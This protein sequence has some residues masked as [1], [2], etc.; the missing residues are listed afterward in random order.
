MLQEGILPQHTHTH[1]QCDSIITGLKLFLH[2]RTYPL[3]SAVQFKV[4]CLDC[5]KSPLIVPLLK[6]FMKHTVWNSSVSCYFSWMVVT[7]WVSGSPISRHLI[8]CEDTNLAAIWCK[9][10][11]C[12]TVLWTD[13]HEIANMLSTLQGFNYSVIDIKLLYF[14]RIL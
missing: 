2:T 6:H 11:L 10:G 9:F 4:A 5:T 13:W 3:I 14:F 7:L 12:L 1:T 8:T